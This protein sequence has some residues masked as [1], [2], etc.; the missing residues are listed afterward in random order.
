VSVGHRLRAAQIAA[1]VGAMTALIGVIVRWFT[2]RWEGRIIE[3]PEFGTVPFPEETAAITG[4]D[5]GAGL[6]ALAVLVGLAA[7][8]ALLAGRRARPVALAVSMLGA[9][10]L[11]VLALM[12]G[13]ADAIAAALPPPTAG[14]G[15]PTVVSAAGRIVT[16]VGAAIV[17]VGAG[18]G[19]PVASS[20]GEVRMPERAPD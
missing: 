4:A 11:I 17:A 9:L 8:L 2:V 7:V 5:L 1:I 16:I 12:A 19:L 20:V 10:G 13:A 15:E 3:V 18:W 6:P 14:V